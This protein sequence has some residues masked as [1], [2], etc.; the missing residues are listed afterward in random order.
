MDQVTQ[1]EKK[2]L[3]WINLKSR[4]LQEEWESKSRL[5]KIGLIMYH[6]SYQL[7][8]Y[9]VGRFI[10]PHRYDEYRLYRSQIHH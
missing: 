3:Y 4:R 8:I 2:Y 9:T 7:Y 5:E 1:E 10:Q 6:G